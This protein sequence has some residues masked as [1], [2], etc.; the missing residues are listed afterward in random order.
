MALQAWPLALLKGPWSLA[1]LKGPW[2]LAL[3]LWLLH[4]TAALSTDRC[5][6]ERLVDTITEMEACITQIGK[7]VDFCEAHGNI[8]SCSR[9]GLNACFS[10]AQVDAILR[11]QKAELRVATEAV[12]SPSVFVDVALQEQVS[13]LLDSC[14][15]I[16]SREEAARV[17][18]KRLY[19]LDYV[20]TDKNCSLQEVGGVQDRLA[21]C[22]DKQTVKFQ[23]QVGGIKTAISLKE[24]VCRIID[25]TFGQCFRLS[26]P[27]CFSDRDTAYL[28][29]Q[30]IE[31]FREGLQVSEEPGVLDFSMADCLA[32]RLRAPRVAVRASSSRSGSASQ[33]DFS[34][35][36]TLLAIVAAIVMSSL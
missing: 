29:S 36:L 21:A 22:M 15:Y 35:H 6:H 32:P 19:W 20:Y 2:S 1:L 17:Q 23:A 28:D 34:S 10:P 3:L 18:L 5:E 12:F 13:E 4:T 9:R 11:V 8:L 7:E 31:L 24:K 30:S 27:P 14:Y 33:S 16:P 25:R 26:Y